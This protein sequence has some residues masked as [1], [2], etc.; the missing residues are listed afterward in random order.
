MRHLN[1]FIKFISESSII[2][3]LD[4]SDKIDPKKG[5]F[6]FN[7][8]YGGEFNSDEE[9]LQKKNKITPDKKYLDEVILIIKE[10]LG[11]KIINL[12]WEEEHRQIYC[13]MWNWEKRDM[14]SYKERSESNEKVLII[15]FYDDNWIFCAIDNDNNYPKINETHYICD[16]IFGFKNFLKN[17]KKYLTNIH[18]DIAG[19]GIFNFG[20]NCHV[21]MLL[22]DN[23]FIQNFKRSLPKYKDNFYMIFDG[24]YIKVDGNNVEKFGNIIT[25]SNLSK[26]YED[27]F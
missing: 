11:D 5:Y 10:M 7:N 8:T 2:K 23:F 25:R 20:L 9:F 26:Y 27:L 4:F 13:W 17:R 1:N 3:K 16:D 24:S 12:Y 18:E 6:K 14:M 15:D 22:N 19:I 21:D